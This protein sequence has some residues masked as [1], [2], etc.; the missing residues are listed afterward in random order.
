[1]PNLSSPAAAMATESKLTRDQN[2]L[3]AKVAEQSERY[4][5]MSSFMEDVVVSRDVTAEITTDERNLVSVAFKNLVASRRASWRIVNLIETKEEERKNEK[6]I[7]RVKNYKGK[8]EAELDE[9]C[10]RI[11]GLLDSHLI[12]AAESAEAKVFYWKMKGDYYRY[13]AEFKIGDEK[14][15]KAEK[16]LEAYVQ[17]QE[18]AFANLS[19]THPVRLGLALNYSVFYFEILN[20]PEM[21]CSVAKQAFEDA[22]ADLDSLPE[23]SYRDST[24][25]MQLMRDNLTIW[26]ADIR[27]HADIDKE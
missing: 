1:M 6:N 11:L 3:L 22:I 19:S 7:N 9:I 15:S 21:A 14:R 18:I 13:L 4:E 10:N 23:E 17:A 26:T 5:E 20:Q 8:I 27:E 25:I 12:P 16:T 2:V 24:V